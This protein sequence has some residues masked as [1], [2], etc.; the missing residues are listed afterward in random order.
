MR[1]LARALMLLMPA[2][3]LASA[4]PA[5][6]A[7]PE[8]AAVREFREGQ[9]AYAHGDF[10][11]AASRFE[12]AFRDDPRGAIVFNAGLSWQAAGEPARA[13]DDYAFALATTDLPAENAGDARTRLGA[14]EKSLGRIDVTAPTGARVSVAHADRLPPPAHVHVAPGRYTVTV[15]LADESTRQRSVSVRAGE[16]AHLDFVV[17]RSATPATSPAPVADE[18]SGPAPAA[19]EPA[20]ASSA[21]ST[22]RTWGWITLGI[23]GVLAGVSGWL[24]VQFFDA[25]STNNGTRSQSTYDD[26]VSAATRLDV[27]LIVTALTAGVGIGLLITAPTAPAPVAV[28]ATPGGASLHVSF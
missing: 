6:A 14:L 17:D 16:W 18:P 11:A 4:H 8:S 21:P 15:L 5:A 13:A 19:P 20:A 12:A 9:Q 27:G 25:N 26:A 3:C 23:A 2:V 28:S 1:R 10:K 7:E 22:Q 24:T